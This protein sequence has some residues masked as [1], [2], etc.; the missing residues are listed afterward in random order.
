MQ[1][2][3]AIVFVFKKTKMDRKDLLK[4]FLNKD[5]GPG[6]DT[7]IPAVPEIYKTLNAPQPFLKDIENVHVLN[8]FHR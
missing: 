6:G 4:R 7:S 3:Y 2:T 5:V 8:L 1:V